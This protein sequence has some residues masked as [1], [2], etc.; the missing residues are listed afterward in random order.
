MISK[1]LI[2]EIDRGRLGLNQGISMGLPKFESIV[3]GVSRETYT[4]ILSNSGAGKTSF[5]L[6]AYVYK[7]LM[8]SL[9]DDNFKILYFSLE[10]NEVSLFIK[11]L[12]IYIFETYGIELSFKKILSREREYTLSDEHYELVQQCMPWIDKISKKLE[13]YDKSVSANKV[14]AILKTR[15]ESMGRF[16]ET[17]TR[18]TYVPNNPNL[19]YNVIIDHIGLVRPAQGNTLKQEIDLLSSYLV[20]LREKCG[21]SPVVI[22][23]A[24]REQG[25]IERFKQG[26]SAFSIN[27]AKDSGNT[28]QDCNI[29]IAIYNPNRDGLKTYKKYN[30]EQ[31]GNVFRSVQVLKNR[32]GDCDV[33]VGMNFFGGINTFH[34]LPKPDE[35]YD[36]ERYINPN[37]ILDPSNNTDSENINIDNNKLDEVN[38]DF[39]FVL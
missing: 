27:D 14:Y 4:L 1:K 20:T 28:V 21:I 2:E 25:N 24:N 13:I 32:F 30:I 31:L 18:Y 15:L 39:K 23:Q 16:K 8:E 34:E 11:L 29:M 17:E 12:S 22:Q 37:Y 6:Y 38:D 7:P 35:I 26:K 5:A 3:D 36:Y 19:I 33:E 9:D 10:M